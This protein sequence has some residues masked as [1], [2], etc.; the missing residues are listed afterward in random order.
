MGTPEQRAAARWS[1][2]GWS[3]VLGLV[4]VLAVWAA[5]QLK[6]PL[7]VFQHAIPVTWP[8]HALGQH[9]AQNGLAYVALWLV[10]LVLTGVAARALGTPF[11]PYAAGFTVLFVLAGVILVIGSQQTLKTYGLEYPFWALLFGVVIG[12][13]IRLPGWLAAAAGRTE[14]FI[15]TSIVLLGANLPFSIIATSGPRGFVEALVIV[16]LGFTVAFIV[17]KRLGIDPLYISILGAGASVC[18]VSAAIAVGN[19]VRAPQRKV[20]Y[21]VSLVVVYGLILVFLLPALVHLLGLSNTVGGAW[22]GGSELADA[23]GAAAAAIL[24]DTAVSTFSLVKLSRDVLIS[25]IC[26]ILGAVAATRWNAEAQPSS[27]PWSELWR[28]F[29]KFVLAF[30]I[31]SLLATWWQAAYGKAF[32][33]DF[34]ANLNAVRTWLFTLTF[35]GVGLNTRFREVREVG[36]RAIALFTTVVI[37][38]VIAGLILAYLLFNGR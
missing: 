22:I 10:L 36:G 32:N 1:E 2:D 20:G 37:V 35:F 26:L 24:G 7:D 19:A 25:V 29:P 8:A 3:V 5:Y 6:Q 27:S 17:G 13:L 14:L 31:A 16:A 11:L 33:T 38:N 23:S 28:R 34:T 15:K 4:L 30:V 18:G 12:N 9:F 21:V